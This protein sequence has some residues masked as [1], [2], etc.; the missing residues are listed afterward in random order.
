MEGNLNITF[1][2]NKNSILDKI[3]INSYY[4]GE[5]LKEENGAHAARMQAGV[6]NEDVLKD[7][8]GIAAADVAA[9]ITRNLGRCVVRED[10]FLRVSFNGKVWELESKE[11]APEGNYLRV[12]DNIHVYIEGTIAAGEDVTVREV[13]AGTIYNGTVVSLAGDYSFETVAA[14][15]FPM[16]LKKAVEGAIATYMFDKA[17]EGWLLIN[18]PAE[19]QALAQRS[20]ADAEKLRQLLV[21][22]SKPIR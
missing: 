15:N 13:V 7:E 22:R 8:I 12:E 9:M 14:S 6:D 1:A 10:D 16:S 19:V 20:V 5:R 17:L 4:R 21:E 18:M 2:V 3:A 11:D